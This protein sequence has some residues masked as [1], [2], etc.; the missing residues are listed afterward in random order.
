MGNGEVGEY[1]KF[2]NHLVERTHNGFSWISAL[3]GVKSFKLATT[4]RNIICM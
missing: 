2:K 1:K 3:A 4:S